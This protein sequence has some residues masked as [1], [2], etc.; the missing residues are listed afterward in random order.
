MPYKQ[1]P[2]MEFIREVRR[3]IWVMVY[4]HHITLIGFIRE[5]GRS[6]WGAIYAHH[7]TLI[8]FIRETGR[9]IW[10]AIYAHHIRFFAQMLRPYDVYNVCEIRIFSWGNKT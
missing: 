8:G 10:G 2:I 6:I 7:I 4:A 1:I 5:T 9:S 3:C